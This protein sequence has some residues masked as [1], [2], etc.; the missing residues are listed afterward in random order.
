M[1]NGILPIPLQMNLETLST[2]YTD[3]NEPSCQIRENE[4]ETL[5]YKHSSDPHA[6]FDS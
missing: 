5:K 2:K 4:L 1:I 3:N 6:E